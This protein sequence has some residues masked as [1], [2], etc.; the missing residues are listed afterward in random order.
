VDAASDHAAGLGGH[1]AALGLGRALALHL[2]LL[3][4]V[5]EAVAPAVGAL[6][7]LGPL[8]DGVVLGAALACLVARLDGGTRLGR[9]GVL[10]RLGLGGR[11][12]DKAEC[13]RRRECSPDEHGSLPGFVAS[14]MGALRLRLMYPTT[15]TH[16]L[17]KLRR[18][19]KPKA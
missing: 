9:D 14:F 16:G 15:R 19:H 5:P 4:P 2:L 3:G 6:H 7:L 11:R 13:H 1:R 12:R 8:G 17:A 18:A 10:A